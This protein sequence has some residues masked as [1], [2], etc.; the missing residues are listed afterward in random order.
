MR[1]PLFV[2][3]PGTGG[4]PNKYEHLL[5]MVAYAGYRTIGLAY[6]SDGTVES[7]CAGQLTCGSN[8]QGLVRDELITGQ[9]TS[10]NDHVLLGDA[11]LPRLYDLL[12]SLYGD[13]MADGV[14]DYGTRIM[15]PR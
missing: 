3:L 6:D 2:F 7:A 1:A 14:N 10:V 9:D 5:K 15:S 13:D 12:T 11:I 8:C 4:E